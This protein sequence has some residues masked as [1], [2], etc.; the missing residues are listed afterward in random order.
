MPQ[1]L[2]VLQNPNVAERVV[3]SLRVAF[4]ILL[5]IKFE[6]PCLLPMLPTLLL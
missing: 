4:S 5:L 6:T 3:F 1:L 2:L